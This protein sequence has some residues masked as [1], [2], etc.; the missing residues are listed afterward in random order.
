MQRVVILGSSG[1]GKTELARRLGERTGLPVVHLDRIFWREGWQPAPRDEAEA[2]LVDVVARDR[3]ILDGDFRGAG[4]ARFER[5]D[6]VL[7]L[8]TPRW[9]CIWRVLWRRVRDH[10]KERPDLP[11]SEAFDWENLKWIWRYPRTERSEILAIPGVHVLRSRRD[12]DAMV[13]A[14]G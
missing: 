3:W 11:A 4:D 14:D 8:D 5:A 1:A 10:G 6:T 7:F 13:H 2:E 9:L 12:V